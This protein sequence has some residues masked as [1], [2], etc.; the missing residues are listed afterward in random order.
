MK[1]FHLLCITGLLLVACQPSANQSTTGQTATGDSNTVYQPK[2]YVEIQ[3]PD[4]TKNATIYEVNVRQYTPAG[5]FKAFETHLPRLKNM[6]IDILWI[7]P[8]N[9]IG[10][11]NR[12]GTLG[13]EYAVKDYYGVNSEFG[14][15]TDFKHLVSTAH[16]MGMH[17]ILDWVANHS[18]WDNALVTQHPDWYIKNREGTFESTPWRDYDD[19]IDFD[20]SQLGLRNYMTDAMKYWIKETDLDG[21]RCDV[22]S[23][24]PIDFWEAARKELDQVKPV[25]MLAEAADRDLHKRAFDMTYSW[26]LWDDLHAITTKGGSVDALTGGYIAEQVSIW[27]RNAYRLNFTD[28]HDKNAWEGNQ[29]SNFGKG[30]P[31][32]I[33]LTVTMDGM[34]LIYSGQEAGLDHSLRFFDK[35]PIQWKPDTIAGIFTKLFRL[36]HT[37]QAIWNG[38]W[39]GEMERIKNDKMSQVISFISKV[40]KIN[41]TRQMVKLDA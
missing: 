1:L 12:K 25:F 4:W 17:V 29:Y 5:T 31:A 19:I 40:F 36:K 20:Y 32:A 15:L 27:P 30:L 2:E 9:P 35:D 18:A 34:P 8:V 3:H 24:V 6:G 16:S 10:E 38:K 37:N 21:F 28:N 7:M 33:V 22:A 26:L 13:S 39:G 23:F 14:T 11:K 41:P